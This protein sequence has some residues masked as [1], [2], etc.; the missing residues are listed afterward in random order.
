MFRDVV[1]CAELLGVEEGG[2]LTIQG[3]GVGDRRQQDLS[4]Q[5]QRGKRCV[6]GGSQ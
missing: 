3:D 4:E 6:S 1:C 5:A 2:T